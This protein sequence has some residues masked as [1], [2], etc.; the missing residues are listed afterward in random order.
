MCVDGERRRGRLGSFVIA[1]LLGSAAGVA[2]AGRVRVRRR[3]SV[4]ATPAG[5]AAFERAPCYRE[6]VELEA[7]SADG[8][9]AS[10]RE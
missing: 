4:R 5:L 7:S 9:K 3:R 1:G 10:L 2:A 6:L 8:D